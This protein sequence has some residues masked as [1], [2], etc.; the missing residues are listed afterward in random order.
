MNEGGQSSTG[1]V[2]GMDKVDIE[3]TDIIYSSLTLLLRHIQHT[4]SS[5][6]K[7]N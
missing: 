2:G 6:N 3:A 1:Q 4:Q 5:R 7:P